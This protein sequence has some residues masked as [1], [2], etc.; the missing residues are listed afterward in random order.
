MFADQ[1]MLNELRAGHNDFDRL[2]TV[3]MGEV[4]DIPHGLV[5]HMGLREM[6][7]IFEGWACHGSAD[8][9]A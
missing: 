8:Q 3:W 2:S 5:I 4:V 6:T 7:G 9:L 1:R